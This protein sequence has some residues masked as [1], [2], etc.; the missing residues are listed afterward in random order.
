MIVSLSLVSCRNCCSVCAIDSALDTASSILAGARATFGSGAGGST[1]AFVEINR[2]PTLGTGLCGTGT[3]ATT[4]ATFG[5]GRGSGVA[6]G[7]LLSTSSRKDRRELNLLPGADGAGAF[8]TNGPCSVPSGAKTSLLLTVERVSG[9][10]SKLS[11]LLSVSLLRWLLSDMP[12]AVDTVLAMVLTTDSRTGRANRC[13]AA[14]LSACRR[15]LANTPLDSNVDGAAVIR[16]AAA[17][18]PLLASALSCFR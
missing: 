4:N 3:G 1:A 15:S 16:G 14:I 2:G 7:A 8:T 10:S 11:L 5:A 18:K 9:S 13:S 12:K 6:G 17:P